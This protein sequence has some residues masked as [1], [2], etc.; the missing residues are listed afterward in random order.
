MQRNVVKV[1]DVD[2]RIKHG[3]VILTEA[4]RFLCNCV[5]EMVFC[6]PGADSVF[7]LKLLLLPFSMMRMCCL[8][9]PQKTY[10]FHF[11]T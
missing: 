2:N 10:R 5:L 4:V 11:G 3:M 9:S 7:V 6:T 1:K 8:H